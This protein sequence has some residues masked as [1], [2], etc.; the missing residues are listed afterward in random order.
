MSKIHRF[1]AILRACPPAICL[2]LTLCASGCGEGP[3]ISAESHELTLS[4]PAGMALIPATSFPSGPWHAPVALND[5]TFDP[6]ASAILNV[7][8]DAAPTTILLPA[9]CVD[10][11]S[12][13]AVADGTA[14]S[15]VTRDQAAAICRARGLRLCSAYEWELACRGTALSRFAYGNRYDPNCGGSPAGAQPARCQSSYGVYDQL[16]GRPEWVLG[17]LVHESISAPALMGGLVET[18][19]PASVDCLTIRYP[20][21]ANPAPGTPATTTAPGTTEAVPAAMPALLGRIRCCG[22]PQAKSQYILDY[23]K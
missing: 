1:A 19:E 12:S 23:N 13:T 20:G 21:A 6:A 2:V 5:E 7:A 14:E 9:Y 4:C 17:P 16:G 8:A 22:D 3:V 15:G 10:R 18:E 11:L